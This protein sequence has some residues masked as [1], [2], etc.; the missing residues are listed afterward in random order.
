MYFNYLERPSALVT[1]GIYASAA[2]TLIS[3]VHYL[4]YAAKILNQS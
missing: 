1:V 2:I 4:A 3:G